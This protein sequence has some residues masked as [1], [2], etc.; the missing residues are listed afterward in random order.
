MRLVLPKHQEGQPFW[1]A[2][3]PSGL[4]LGPPTGIEHRPL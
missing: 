2:R 4:R 3:H 1:T